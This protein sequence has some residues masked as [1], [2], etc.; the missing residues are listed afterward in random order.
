MAWSDAYQ[1][2]LLFQNNDQ[3]GAERKAA[4][5]SATLSATGIVKKNTAVQAT[6][7]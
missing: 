4:A 6:K 2:Q 3:R 1:K 5:D 7:R